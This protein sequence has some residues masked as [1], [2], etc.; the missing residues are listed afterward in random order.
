M[1]NELSFKTTT[2]SPEM[3]ADLLLQEMS[4]QEKMSQL[5]CHFPRTLD[6]SDLET[7]HPLGV[8]QISCLEIR[9][10]DTLADASR[11]TRQVQ[12]TV[13]SLSPHRIPAILHM[14]GLCGAYIPGAASFPSGI[15]RAAS[16]NLELEEQIGRIVARQEQ[17]IGITQ[18]F[19]PVLDISRDSRMGRQGETYGEDP[20]LAAALGAAMTRGLQA[21]SIDGRHTD[22]VAK[23]FLGFHQGEAGIHGAHCDIPPRLLREVFAKPFQA[24]ISE[25][26]LM[27]IMPCYGSI[28]SE[29]VSSSHAILTGLLR[30]EMGFSGVTVS[31]YCAIMNIHGVQKVCE[32]FTEAGLA[33]LS[34]G[35][36]MELHF[37]KCYND[38][39]AGWFSDGRAD[40]AILDRAVRRVLTAKFRMGLFE[41]PFGLESAELTKI[42]SLPGDRMIS[43]Q[44][45]LQSL[46]LLK[47]NG[48]LPID[49]NIRKIALI[50]Y[51]AGTARALFGGYTHFSMREGLYAAT[52]TMAG[53][54][55]GNDQAQ[56]GIDTYPGSNIQI[57][58][59]AC[60]DLLKILAPQ[61]PSVH[62]QLVRC[63]PEIEITYSYGYP[64]VGDD[65][66]GHDEALAAAASADL[67]ILTLGGKH[68]TSSIAS[69][70]EGLD[71]T[72]INLPVCQEVLIEKLAVLGKPMIG[73]HFN[74]RPISSDAAD[75]HL[76]AILEAWNPAEAG[77][78]AIVDVL[79]GV[80][81]PGGKL[82]VSVAYKGGQIPV[83]YN[84]PNGSGFHQG[85]SIGLS[86]Y[87]DC[88]HRPRYSFGHGLSYTSFAYTGLKI[89]RQEVNPNGKLEISLVV[90][91]TGAQCGDEVVQL[92]ISDRYASVTRPNME[93]AGFKRVTLMPGES[94]KLLF[95]LEMSQLAFV[96][97]SDRWKVEAGDFD[98]KIGSSSQDIRLE[99]NFMVTD[100][101]YIDG[102]TR[103]FYAKTFSKPAT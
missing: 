72:D 80:A 29:P 101:Q 73:I 70:G 22:A 13:I 34:A 93:L 76:S 26:G 59:A 39:L 63:L 81:G 28:N 66:S 24:A 75:K 102:R 87:V 61:A 100:D 96:D 6:F 103:S 43:Y 51:H 77:T 18:T 33:A 19:A 99:G 60:E 48:V 41:H 1:K 78:D 90:T 52:A 42:F 8:G 38:E 47:N 97:R 86:D 25:A 14:E 45:A 3:R 9:A 69:M 88:P 84:H 50:G 46:V 62:E 85:E 56:A 65:A 54:K 12:Q 92:Y 17:A 49:R 10:F 30:D 74:G 7:N 79:T 35:M 27:G 4:V 37:Q 94:W 36:D 68:G 40:M 2:L 53:V 20:T 21:A 71:S 89:D 23:H 64:Y 32:N 95:S 55:S 31:D 15:G 67:V 5:V 98:I 91:N 58:P 82:P 44:S 16:W 83:Y 11:F 57:E